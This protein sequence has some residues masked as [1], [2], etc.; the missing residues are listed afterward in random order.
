[1][2][3]SPLTATPRVRAS[4]RRALVFVLLI[5]AGVSAALAH[6][7]NLSLQPTAEGLRGQAIYADGAPARGEVVALFADN[8]AHGAKPQAQVRCD[9]D[10]RF[11]FALN[12]AGR[13]RVVVEGDEG[14]RVEAHLT[15]S[16][17]GAPTVGAT[18]VDSAV[19]AAALRDEL[20]PLREDI[21]RLQ[22]RIRLSDVVGGIGFVIG[23]FGAYAW[24]RTRAGR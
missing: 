2:R 9:E 8:A 7:L 6:G 15:W 20:A 16:A 10:G 4:A 14:H 5:A 13:Y 12:A 23:V 21:A 3:S 19:L 11:Q 17:P 22:A 24:W 18:A 1:M